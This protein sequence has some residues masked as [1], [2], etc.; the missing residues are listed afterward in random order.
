MMVLN[1]NT[2]KSKNYNP[3]GADIPAAALVPLFFGGPYNVIFNGT[4]YI[5]K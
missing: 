4:T 5:P 1:M 3:D 2:S